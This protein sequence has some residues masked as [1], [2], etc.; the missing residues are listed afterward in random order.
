MLTIIIAFAFALFIALVMAM[1]VIYKMDEN[2]MLLS[3]SHENLKVGVKFCMS[4][5]D[6]HRAEIN[7]LKRQVIDS[8]SAWKSDENW[9]KVTGKKDK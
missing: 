3:K 1:M 4:C 8:Q 2:I 7:K 5:L 6:D 9:D